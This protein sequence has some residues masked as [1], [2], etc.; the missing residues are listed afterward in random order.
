MNT[1]T[2][3]H[4]DADGFGWTVRL[5]WDSDTWINFEVFRVVGVD[6]DGTRQVYEHKDWKCSGDETED[7][8]DAH[9]YVHG[10]L[11]WDGCSHVNFGRGGYIHGCNADFDFAEPSEAL[12][13]AFT[14]AREQMSHTDFGPIGG[15]ERTG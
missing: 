13:L 4:F 1:K 14:F 15:E 7:I 9:P 10:T 11:K 8:D 3:N 5:T 12:R 6:G 2:R